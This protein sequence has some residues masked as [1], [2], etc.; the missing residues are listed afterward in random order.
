MKSLSFLIKAILLGVFLFFINSCEE[1]N[2][3]LTCENG[4][5]NEQNCECDPCPEGF[6]GPDCSIESI[7]VSCTMNP[8]SCQ[9][10]GECVDGQ[11][12]CPLGFEGDSCQYVV[13]LDG[14]LY[15]TVVIGTQTWLKSDLKST[16]CDD[17]TPILHAEDP[18]AWL[19]LTSAGYAWF[20]NLPDLY[21]DAYGLIYNWYAV[22]D[23]NV[24]PLG[25]HVPTNEEWFILA[26][27]LDPEDLD[28]NENL[29]SEVA[30]G[31]MKA[32]GYTFW[33]EPNIGAT[34]ESGWT[35]LP[36]GRRF[37]EAEFEHRGGIGYWWSATEVNSDE[38]F[39]YELYTYDS[40]LIRLVK[41]KVVGYSI[42]CLKD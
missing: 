24:C 40:Y 15:E 5:L 21:D 9:N 8:N 14:N 3:D 41:P 26:D 20:Y 39:F 17:G 10:G 13:D 7:G 35:G 36:G 33:D 25:W 16:H 29:V 12:D 31:K 34:N 32:S 30:G 19:A 38:A 4:I 27:Y 42:R 23:C 2:C 28:P 6:S 11:C 1:E 22:S 18:D 37:S